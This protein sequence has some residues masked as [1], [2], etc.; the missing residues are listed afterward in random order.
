MGGLVRGQTTKPH[1]CVRL[2]LGGWGAA[3]K[4]GSQRLANFSGLLCVSTEEPGWKERTG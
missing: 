4:I 3:I 2:G 1:A